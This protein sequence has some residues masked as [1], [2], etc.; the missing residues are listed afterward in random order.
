M[1]TEELLFNAISITDPSARICLYFDP[2]REVD[3]YLPTRHVTI[4]FQRMAILTND[5]GLVY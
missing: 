4:T 5:R 1:T 2:I 3:M